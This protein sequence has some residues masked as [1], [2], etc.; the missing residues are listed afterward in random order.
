[1]QRWPSTTNS[2]PHPQIQAIIA[3]SQGDASQL[4]ELQKQLKQA[5]DLVKDIASDAGKLASVLDL[6]DPAE[7]S[8][9]WL[10]I[11]CA[12]ASTALHLCAPHHTASKEV[13][14]IHAL[15]LK[16]PPP[17]SALSRS[18]ASSSQ[19][20]QPALD[21]IAR[22]ERFLAVCKPS[23]VRLSPERRAF[24]ALPPPQNTLPPAAA[25]AALR[26]RFS[27]RPSASR[28]LTHSHAALR[29]IARA[30]ASLC[31]A[32]KDKA[33]KLDCPARAIRPLAHAV[34]RVQ[35]TPQHLTPQHADFLQW[36]APKTCRRRQRRSITAGAL[37]ASKQNRFQL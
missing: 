29:R 1:M 4:A 3:L 26:A 24:S 7:Q 15:M 11:L 23:H 25:A 17:C 5:D 2:P 19:A 27:P 35:P 12:P 28:R 8:L 36:R 20:H 32:L 9:A 16:V 13:N 21:F 33:V 6:L 37:D 18:D 14:P 34:R 31:K 30:V 22:A 10:H